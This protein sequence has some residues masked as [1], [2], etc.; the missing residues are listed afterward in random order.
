MKGRIVRTLVAAGLMLVSGFAAAAEDP[1]A[2]APFAEDFETRR[3]AYLALHA[4]ARSTNPYTEAARLAM[5]RPPREAGIQ[6][7]LDI[8]DRRE[9]CADFRV[10]GILR[11][12]YQ[13][14]DR[15]ELSEAVRAR[16]RESILN[17][18]YWPDEPGIDSMCTWS[19]NHYIMFT[20][21][22]YLAGQLFP[23]ATFTN[24][25]QTGR[26]KMAVC[27]PRILRW[28][29]L[30]YRAGFSEW[31]SNTYYIHDLAPLLNLVD[32]CQDDAIA[33]RAAMVVDLLLT[34]MALN[35]FHGA[36]SATHGRAYERPKKWAKDESTASVQKL[37]FGMNRFGP[38][39]RAAVSL[40][41]SERYRMPQA[42]YAMATDFDRSEMVNRQRMGL[43][44][45]EARQWGLDF[46]RLE[47][48]MLF[49]CLEA[50]AHPR[51]IDLTMRMMDEYDWWDNVFFEP[52][53]KQ[54]PLLGMARKLHLLPLVAWWFRRD[55]TRT[56][57]EE[58]NIYTYRTP[59]YMLSSAQDYR[60]GYG[61]A[62]QH[63]WQATLGLD[64]ACFTTHPA[65]S[66]DASPGYWV[67]SGTLPRVGQ[68]KNVV[69]ALYD[70]SVRPGLLGID[71]L[72]LTHAWLPKDRF[73][74][75]L[76]RDGWVFARRD[77]GYLALWSER[78]YRWQT[79]AGED[80]DREII[81]EGKKNIWICEMGRRAVDGGFDRFV[82]RIC[83]A[84]VHTDG[85]RVRY[86][87]PSQGRLEFAW[88]GRLRQDGEVV[89]LA[90][91]PRYGNPYG[92]APFP[93]DDIQLEHNGEWLHLNWRTLERKASSFAGEAGVPQTSTCA[94]NGG[95]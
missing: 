73:D 92:Q 56:V 50:H 58:V 89:P 78:P 42:I 36:F 14:G 33:Q 39:D 82:D 57:L 68:V 3:Q 70:V 24:S 28:L 75:V 93:G 5:G 47:D 67:G 44:L 38:G 54:R 80:H 53:K 49:L 83:R 45:D 51:M 21:G 10:N 60:K 55:V 9:D 59:D 76:E 77:D 41:L 20:A 95:P 91:Y 37:L 72:P 11:L 31:L 27:R 46:N 52:F 86:D 23:E 16:A 43:R 7:A 34:D 87:S 29:E 71:T 32:F 40:A 22:G 48:G 65:K 74:E 64:A 61:G 35:S 62:Q 63:V 15:P 79:E 12:L 6:R 18:K 81:A 8:I 25:G 90:D 84:P 26:E 17:F 1:Y 2:Y 69:L 13:F 94:R 30:R 88:H 19:E 85:L 4:H 66:R